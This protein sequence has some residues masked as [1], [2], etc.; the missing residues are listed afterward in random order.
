MR[1]DRI[2][3][4]LPSRDF[5][6]T[7]AF[8]ARLGFAEVYRDTGW[9]ILARDTMEVEFVHHPDLVPEESWHSACIRV[10]D[11]DGLQQTWDALE[12]PDD[13]MGRPRDMSLIENE[14]GV[15]F[16]CVIDPDGSLLRCIDN[17]SV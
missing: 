4:N 17:G 15:R 5:E 7:C 8:Y 12:L 9:L 11:L 16:F 6:A 1:A 3:A 14:N 13:P 10:D 2:T